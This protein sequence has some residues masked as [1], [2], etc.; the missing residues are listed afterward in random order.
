MTREEMTHDD[1]LD[2]LS[3]FTVTAPRWSPV[4]PEYVKALDYNEWTEHWNERTASQLL[5]VD[6]LLVELAVAAGEEAPSVRHLLRSHDRAQRRVVARLLGPA[7]EY[8]T[9]LEFRCERGNVER[10]VRR[11][12]E[13]NT[14]DER[15]LWATRAAEALVESIGCQLLVTRRGAAS[16]RWVAG[17]RSRRMVGV[18][19]ATLAAAH[20]PVPIHETRSGPLRSTTA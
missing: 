16:A 12:T 3:R 10:F 11:H 14:I 17:E 5:I 9:A 19:L 4:E 2:R 13:G 7:A 6:G 8:F 1:L 18:V 15:L 20:D